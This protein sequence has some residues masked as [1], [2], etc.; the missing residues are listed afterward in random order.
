MLRRVVFHAVVREIV[1]EAAREPLVDRRVV[2]EVL[3]RL[4]LGHL[5]Y[6][7]RLDAARLG[8]ATTDSGKAV[9]RIQ[10]A[11]VDRCLAG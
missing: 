2:V 6:R 10:I 5:Q 4:F 8:K 11:V 3:R 9:G 7:F 1:V